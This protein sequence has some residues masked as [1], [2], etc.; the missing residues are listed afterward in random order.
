[1][2]ARSWSKLVYP[3]KPGNCCLLPTAISTLNKSQFFRQIRNLNLDMTAMPSRKFSNDLTDSGPIGIH[4]Q[5]A[6]ATSL[7]NIKITMPEGN[8]V[9]HI[10]IDTENGS[11]GFV[12]DVD[13]LN[14]HIGWRVG[15]Q[16]FTARKTF[17]FLFT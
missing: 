4:W 15:S 16:Q 3:S 7:Q 1:M 5:I 14:G 2:V 6:Q 17:F 12:C 8:D 10:G 13:V 11:G 9:S